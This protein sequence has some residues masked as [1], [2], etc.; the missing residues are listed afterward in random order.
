MGNRHDWREQFGA[1]E[2]LPPAKPPVG[3]QTVDTFRPHPL[4]TGN[5]PIEQDQEGVRI[6][7]ARHAANSGASGEGQPSHSVGGPQTP[8]KPPSRKPKPKPEVGSYQFDP[9]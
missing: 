4:M 8:Q 9:G 3:A 5:D 2:G 6:G 1:V 7:Q